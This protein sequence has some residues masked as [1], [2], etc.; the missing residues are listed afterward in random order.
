MDSLIGVTEGGWDD[1]G[2]GASKASRQKNITNDKE[3]RHSVP[4]IDGK[5]Q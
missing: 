2:G 3:H 5:P 4:M 1:E